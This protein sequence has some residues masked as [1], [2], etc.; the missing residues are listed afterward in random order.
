MTFLTPRFGEIRMEDI[1]SELIESHLTKRLN[2]GRRVYTSSAYSI[3]A[4]LKPAT[5]HK[6]FRILRRVDRT[7][8]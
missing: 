6:E 8:S 4:R 5:V 2:T 7:R 3:A 1:T